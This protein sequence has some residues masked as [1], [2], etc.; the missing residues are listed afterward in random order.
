MERWEENG[1]SP[2]GLI[3]QVHIPI[4]C[5]ASEIYNSLTMTLIGWRMLQYR[6]EAKSEKGPR[7]HFRGDGML[8]DVTHASSPD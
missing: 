6:L 5:S 8:E 7:N 3:S 1:K 2:I 4:V